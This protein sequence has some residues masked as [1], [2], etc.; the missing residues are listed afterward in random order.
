M[1]TRVPMPG[2]YPLAVGDVVLLIDGASERYAT[3][4]ALPGKRGLVTTDG[5]RWRIVRGARLRWIVEEG[6]LAGPRTRREHVGA[7]GL[8]VRR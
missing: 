1:T 8:E 2:L 6:G 3:V 5:T 4:A 7:G